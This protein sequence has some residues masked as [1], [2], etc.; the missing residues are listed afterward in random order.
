MFSKIQY[1]NY[2]IIL[3]FSST[4]KPEHFRSVITNISL[5]PPSQSLI[6]FTYLLTPTQSKF[7]T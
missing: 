2:I 4:F 1:F 6:Y 5:L 3:S 7:Y